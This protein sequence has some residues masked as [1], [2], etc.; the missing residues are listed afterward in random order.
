MKGGIIIY[1]LCLLFSNKVISQNVELYLD[2][3]NIIN[4]KRVDTISNLVS[5]SS[6]I[7]YFNNTYYQANNFPFEVLKAK[8]STIKRDNM[9]YEGYAPITKLKSINKLNRKIQR[10]KYYKFNMIIYNSKNE[11]HLSNESIE[12]INCLRDAKNG[13]FLLSEQKAIAAFLVI[14]CTYFEGA[15]DAIFCKE[16][17][18]ISRTPILLNVIK[19]IN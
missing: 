13:V 16:K 15:H 2:T 12:I 19:I 4:I 7:F 5:E 18:N 6:K 9:F 3:I 1:L 11:K 10:N 14:E 17:I 8:C